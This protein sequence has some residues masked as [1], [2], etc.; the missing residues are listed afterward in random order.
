ML[1]LQPALQYPAIRTDGGIADINLH[2]A[3]LNLE[4]GEWRAN[5]RSNGEIS[6]RELRD[7]EGKVV[8]GNTF[9]APPGGSVARISRSG[10]D[11]VFTYNGRRAEDG[12]FRQIQI[13]FGAGRAARITKDEAVRPD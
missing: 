11:Y 9:N 10:D 8:E 7:K 13:T 4:G 2:S 3:G 5:F 12:T 1:N 6:F